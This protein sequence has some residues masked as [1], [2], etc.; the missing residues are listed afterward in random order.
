MIA[1]KVKGIGLDVAENPLLLLI[2]QQET[3]ILPIG[4]GLTEA[5]AISLKL[6]GYPLP[7]PLIYDLIVSIC[8]NLGGVIEKVVIND[9]YE[10]TFYAQI[11]LKK[12]EKEIIIDIRP[13]DAV[14]LA[15]TSG[16]P[17][18]ITAEVAEHSLPLK[19]IVGGNADVFLC[20]EDDESS[21]LLH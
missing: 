19:E 4:I 5:Q 7:R 15:L 17:L 11:Y 14:V 12:E 3:I 9:F 10:G 20:M 13:S 21:N 2:D 16:C 8:E 6:E 18:Y 1:V